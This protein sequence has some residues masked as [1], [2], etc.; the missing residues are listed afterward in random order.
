MKKWFSVIFR[1]FQYFRVWHP[2]KPP[3]NDWFNC[4]LLGLARRGT[5]ESVLT[6]NSAFL[7]NFANF[8]ENHRISTKILILVISSVF[9]FCIWKYPPGTIGLTIQ[10][11]GLARRGPRS[12][13]L[14][15]KPP[16][17]MKS[18]S[19][20]PLFI[21]KWFWR[22][23]SGFLPKGPPKTPKKRHAAGGFAPRDHGKQKR[24]QMCANGVILPHFHTFAPIAPLFCLKWCFWGPG[25]QTLLGLMVS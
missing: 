7:W 17:V 12:T 11:G 6:G 4:C 23:F 25:A 14:S 18:W 24:G 10:M 2:E 3:R 8:C 21:K 5:E 13:I 16:F 20:Y 22:A 1:E 15:I 19:F 9:R